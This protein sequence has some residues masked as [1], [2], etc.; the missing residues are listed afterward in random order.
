MQN[1]LGEVCDLWGHVYDIFIKI[2]GLKVPGNYSAPFWS[3]NFSICLLKS[4]QIPNSMI[5]GFLDP[6]EPLFM[7][8]DIQNHCYKVIKIRKVGNRF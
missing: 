1:Y 2:I 4:L 5:F 7:D 6:P 8:L 3:H